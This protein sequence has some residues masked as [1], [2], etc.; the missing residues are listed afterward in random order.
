M[1]YLAPGFGQSLSPEV[2]PIVVEHAMRGI[3]LQVWLRGALVVFVLGTLALIPPSPGAI[4]CWVI[5]VLYALVAIAVAVWTRRDGAGSVRYAWLALYVDVAVLSALSMFTGIVAPDDWTADTLQRGFFMIPLL[6]ATQ[7]R[8]FVCLSVVAPTTACYLIVGLVTQGANGEPS[9]GVLL[10]TFV[11]ACLSAAAVWLSA[12]QRSRVRTIGQLADDRSNLLAELMGI[13]ERERRSLAE[14]LHDGAL[15]YVLGARLDLEDLREE[16]RGDALNRL[17]LALAES[18]RLLRS[19]VTELH[20]AVLE[21]SGLPRALE[22]LLAASAPR[23]GLAVSLD[24]DD[25]PADVRTPLDMLLFTAARELVT[26]VVK[27][28]RATRLDVRLALRGDRAELVVADDGVGMAE[29][30]LAARLAEGHIGLQSYRVR[31]EAADGRLRLVRGPAGGT[32]A[33]VELPVQSPVAAAL[34]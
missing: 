13:E 31:L 10:R 1:R 30:L 8:P 6:A 4:T 12:I 5:G 2:R 21:Q 27:H 29:D 26:N 11:V 34:A 22:S 9:N 14:N 33:T 17:D 16:A 32:V 15:Q 7:L 18:S 23:A 3:A 20:P 25:W 19:T 28:A 24:V